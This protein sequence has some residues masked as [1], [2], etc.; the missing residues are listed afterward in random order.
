MQMEKCT[1]LYVGLLRL[2]MLINNRK[3]F[4]NAKEFVYSNNWLN[5]DRFSDLMKEQDNIY[6]IRW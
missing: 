2:I 4:P 1:A 5:I 6:I 3:V